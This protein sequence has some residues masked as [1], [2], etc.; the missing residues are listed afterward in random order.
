MDN[1]LVAGSPEALFQDALALHQ[2]GSG[3]A[4]SL[5]YREVLAA[6]PR[7]FGALYASGVLALQSGD[8]EQALELLNRAV[9]VNPEDA[10]AQYNKGAALHALGHYVEA[11]ASFAHAVRCDPGFY[12]AHENLGRVLQH[13]G[14]LDAAQASYAK[15]L[16]IQPTAELYHERGIILQGLRRAQ[17]ALECFD[18]ALQLKPNAAEVLGNRAVALHSLGRFEECIASC[19]QAI[20]LKPGFV[21]AY[22]NRAVALHALK[23][24][25]EALASY[26]RAIA[27]DPSDVGALHNRGGVLLW[28]KRPDEA[29]ESY[30]RVVTLSPDYPFAKGHLLHAKGLCCE[31]S[32]FETLRRDVAAEVLRRKPS[33]EPFG[34][35]GVSGSEEEL[36]ACAEIYS[37][38]RYPGAAAPAPT[39]RT[40]GGKIRIGY[41]CGEF[42]NQATSILMAELYELH[43]KSRFE[44][45]AF[46]NGWDDRSLMRARLTAAFNE[47]IDISTLPDAAVV[48]KI[49]AMGID[50]LVNLNGYFGRERTAVFARRPAPIQVNYLGFPGTLGTDYIDYLIAD[51]VVIPEDRRR[52]YNE[53]VVYLPH[54]Y[55]AND[56]KRLIA[57]RV[58]TRAELGLPPDG[59]VFCCFNNPYK[60]LPDVFDIWM[61]ILAKVPG[62]S[63]WLIENEPI[64]SH[65]LR[66]E[67]GKR[68][69]DPA[70]LVFAG[71]LPVAEHLARHRAADLFLDTLPY[72]AH[73]TASD[74][75]WAGLPV[76]T[77]TGTAF[78]GRVGTSLLRALDLPELVT[79]TLADYEDLAI[80]LARDPA[81]LKGLKDKLAAHRLT[82]P[83][84]DTPRFTRHIE[85][86][87][88]QMA[89]RQRAGLAP[90]SIEVMP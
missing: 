35:Q 66:A 56:R 30:R 46:D 11:A 87:Y 7:H 14:Q 84:F 41:L 85:D 57:D 48:E 38:A 24:P 81:R 72:N 55:Q 68:G 83:L 10:P 71:R 89:A 5:I 6:N 12:A 21:N 18:A 70:R 65:N 79:T 39:R 25:E 64:A 1:T 40:P 17:E 59:I 63:L 32:D 49:S 37:A 20:A 4:A 31:W 8:A 26:D 73:T 50:I 9:A 23:R 58:F 74:A 51:R 80:A 61:R 88:T 13:M 34:F 54:C 33:A 16:A 47:I 90:V 77:C 2:Q 76:L 43:D 22:N 27:L 28:L 53:A 62:S 36:R 45:Y 15:A 3:E 86:A 75:L 67:A 42:R 44:I 82:K 78:A 60:I 52:N 19:D 69:I 29:L